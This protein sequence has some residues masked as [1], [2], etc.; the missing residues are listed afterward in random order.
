MPSH[1]MYFLKWGEV[2]ERT[3]VKV[4]GKSNI[5]GQAGQEEMRKK[6]PRL[7]Q[8]MNTDKGN[9]QENLVLCKLRDIGVLK[10]DKNQMT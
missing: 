5:K 1:F 2:K 9:N 8:D 4:F 6:K 3:K 10:R 7:F